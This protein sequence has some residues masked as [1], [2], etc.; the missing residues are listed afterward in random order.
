MNLELFTARLRQV[1]PRTERLA[2]GFDFERGD[3]GR[4][5]RQTNPLIDGQPLYRLEPADDWYEGTCASMDGRCFSAAGYQEVLR[6][7]LAHREEPRARLGGAGL[8]DRGRILGFETQLSTYDGAPIVESRGLVDE[9]DAPPIDTWFYLRE[10]VPGHQFPVL[11]CWI[12]KPFEPV[13][14]QTIDVEI[15]G[16]YHWLDEADPELYDQVL[17]RL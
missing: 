6:A 10:H 11:Y 14:Q 4:V 2:A 16:S 1:I 5:F 3:Y 15:M 17:A 8:L 13:M 12:P 9:E 7:A